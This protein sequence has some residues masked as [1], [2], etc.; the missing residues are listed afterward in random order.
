MSR[1]EPLPAVSSQ[2]YRPRTSSFGG[3]QPVRGFPWQ[4]VADSPLG[5]TEEG[6][7]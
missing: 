2:E 3:P 7:P 1:D 5:A 4:G 6:E